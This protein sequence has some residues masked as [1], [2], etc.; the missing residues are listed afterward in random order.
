MRRGET[1][2]QHRA[3]L[4]ESYRTAQ[5]HPP[6]EDLAAYHD[7][8]LAPERDAAVREHIVKCAACIDVILE[9]GA[10]D[11]PSEEPISEAAESAVAAAWCSQMARLRAEDILPVVERRFT[12]RLPWLIAAAFALVSLGLTGWAVTLRQALDE[13]SRPQVNPPLV[14]LTP[15]GAL[16]DPAGEGPTVGLPRPSG[17][18]WLILNLNED[19]DY[20]EYRV[21][22][23]LPGG[24]LLWTLDGL[25]RSPA[26]NFRIELP[27]HL[28]PPS[29]LHIF[30]SGTRGSEQIPIAEY[31]LRFVD[32]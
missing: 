7:G 17:R 5:G 31:R 28:L 18:I 4:V 9:L 29:D 24:R 30:L 6:L 32:H 11:A 16:R 20:P 21:R 25:Q 14:S 3:R 19:V 12:P 27:A 10:I 22:C 2:P 26:G 13:L 8:R 23:L 15:L 1:D